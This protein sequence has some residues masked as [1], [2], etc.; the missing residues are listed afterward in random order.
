M[1]ICHGAYIYL[2]VANQAAVMT[3]C[4]PKSIQTYKILP[5]VQPTPRE[6][7]HLSIT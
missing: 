1:R 6:A 2:S 4:T 5:R 3:D 7:Q